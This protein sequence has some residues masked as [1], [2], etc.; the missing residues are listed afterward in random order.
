MNN[1]ITKTV[2]KKLDSAID[3]VV[4]NKSLFVRNPGKDFTR[5]RLLTMEDVI[6]SYINFSDKSL[7]SEIPELFSDKDVPHIPSKSA[8]IQR[9]DQIRPDAFEQIFYSFSDS[10]DA[11]AALK[12]MRLIAC[13]GSDVNIPHK[14]DYDGTFVQQKGK[15]GYNQIHLNASFDVLN[16]IYTDVVIEPENG[17][18]ERNALCTMAARCKFKNKAVF[19]ADRGYEGFNNIAR[20][21]H[22]GANFLIRLKDISSNGI[23]AS[24]D[25]SGLDD[26]FDINFSTTLTYST[27]NQYRNDASC[28]HILKN[29][30]DFFGDSDTY[31]FSVRVCRFRISENSYECVATSLSRR[32]FPIGMIK[33]IYKLRWNVE[34]GFRKLKYAIDLVHFHSKKKESILKE[35]FSRLIMFNFAQHLYGLIAKTKKL[36]SNSNNKYVYTVNFSAVANACK[37]FLRPGGQCLDVDELCCRDLTA[38]R[39]DRQ[40]P[41]KIHPQSAKPFTYRV[42]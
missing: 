32:R 9:A 3:S 5:K 38:V 15:S 35:I 14:A 17:F 6:R 36:S 31:E 11:P 19:I 24:Y 13:D 22:I 25:T 16:C 27:K 33:N 34:T 21:Q 30:F 4:K 28:T 10:L 2:K 39:P 1:C 29:K 18:D 12:G 26:E 40:Y 8:F 20:L 23:L 37:R 7:T 42:S 41:R